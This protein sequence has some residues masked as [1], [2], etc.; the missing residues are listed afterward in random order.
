MGV[1]C[2]LGGWGRPTAET[3]GYTT[4]LR[5]NLRMLERFYPSVGKVTVQ[6]GETGTGFF[7]S[8][9][10]LFVTCGHVVGKATSAE[11]VHIQLA[12]QE[13]WQCEGTIIRPTGHDLALLTVASRHLFHLRALPCN[14]SWDGSTSAELDA[15]G[16]AKWDDIPSPRLLP[17]KLSEKF[18]DSWIYQSDATGGDSGGPVVFGDMVVGVM[19]R[20]HITERR[21]L[22][23]KFNVIRPYVDEHERCEPR[24]EPPCNR[25][26]AR[27]RFRSSFQDYLKSPQPAGIAYFVSGSSMDAPEQFT[28]ECHRDVIRPLTQSFF[29]PS[30]GNNLDVKVASGTKPSELKNKLS[31]ALGD[32]LQGTGR[33]AATSLMQA[34]DGLN[35]YI[36]HWRDFPHGLTFFLNIRDLPARDVEDSLRILHEILGLIR[37]R[38]FS[39]DKRVVKLPPIVAL[40]SYVPPKSKFSFFQKSG[41]RLS[42]PHSTPKVAWMEEHIGPIPLV[43]AA[44]YIQ[45]LE[46]FDQDNN[47]ARDLSRLRFLIESKRPTLQLA[48]INKALIF[49]GI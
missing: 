14:Y 25:S 29:S 6:G 21:L 10:G 26:E 36:E 31:R 11:Q 19:T 22:A 18:G 13:R 39:Y 12:G 7:V 5:I 46:T 3:P 2:L 1:T 37:D 4:A 49:S 28:E 43:E 20:A 30:G 34:D 15:Y 8:N 41:E 32:R 42:K 9:S 33:V 35:F 16:C 27:K 38:H 17:T 44:E 45:A 40:I 48:D 24:G 47:R 23:E